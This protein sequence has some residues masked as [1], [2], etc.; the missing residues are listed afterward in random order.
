MKILFGVL[1]T[2]LFYC[3]VFAAE[4]TVNLGGKGN[5]KD[6]INFP[7]GIENYG[8]WTSQNT[9]TT[10]TYIYGS[11]VCSG[12]VHVRNGTEVQTQYVICKG[13]S[14]DGYQYISRHT[15]IKDF[16]VAIDD[17]EYIDGS[18][19]WKELIGA[20]C[21]G[22]FLN[23]KDGYFLWNAKCSVTDETMKRINEFANK[24]D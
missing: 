21:T 7:N 5:F 1:I 2:T 15:N 17:F 9:F 4:F 14:H 22:A 13:E 19:P 10:N 20:K 3:N 24:K 12:G 6:N 11:S 16:N 18:G 23:M 8:I